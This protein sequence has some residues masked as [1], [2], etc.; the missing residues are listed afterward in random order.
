MGLS[1]P[2]AKIRN[3]KAPVL[4]SLGLFVAYMASCQLLFV[5]W[6]YSICKCSLQYTTWISVKIFL[7]IKKHLTHMCQNEIWTTLWPLRYREDEHRW[8]KNPDL[9][10]FHQ[11]LE[12]PEDLF[13]Y[14]RSSSHDKTAEIL[15][16]SERT[17]IGYK[18]LEENVSTNL[19]KIKCF[20]PAFR[21]VERIIYQNGILPNFTTGL[22]SAEWA[23]YP[24][25]AF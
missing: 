1:L 7:D 18:S 21:A 16:F 17:R 10:I 23:K 3:R 24:F 14:W 2:I 15:W 20:L 9:E 5:F 19:D 11:L 12:Q 13:L 6:H 4:Q 8:T 25:N 22:T